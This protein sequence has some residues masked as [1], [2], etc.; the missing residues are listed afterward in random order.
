[1]IHILVTN[2]KLNLQFIGG[3]H[4]FI[5]VKSIFLNVTY[6][7]SFNFCSYSEECIDVFFKHIF[8]DKMCDPILTFETRKQMAETIPTN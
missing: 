7:P 4:E 1:M 3:N 6:L 5:L 2:R 8:L